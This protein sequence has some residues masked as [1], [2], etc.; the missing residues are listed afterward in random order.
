MPAPLLPLTPAVAVDDDAL[1]AALACAERCADDAG[2]VIRPHFRARLVVDDKA[3]DDELYDPVTIADRDAETVIRNRLELERPL[4]GLYGEEH[5]FRPGRSGL[6]W[7]IDPIDGTRA[8][9]SGMPLWG[10]LIA[11]YDGERPIAGVMDQ[12]F[13]GERF[14]GSR[15]GATLTHGGRTTPLATR[16]CAQLE[17]A[18]LY[19]THPKLFTGAFE[20]A[21][22]ADLCARVRMTRFSGDCYAYCM[23]AAGQIDLIVE[24]GLKPYDVQALIPIIEAAGGRMSGWKGESGAH[25]GRIVAAGDPLLHAAA[26]EVLAEVP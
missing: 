2:A 21:A 7:V 1:R 17:D 25:G 16:P 18:V 9:I 4:D 22:F 15:L 8:F 24:S 23:L 13:T 20:Q 11:L 26:L 3:G 10:T 5:G 19:S 6:T 14:I 12:P